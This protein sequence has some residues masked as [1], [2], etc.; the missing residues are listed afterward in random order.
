MDAK[1]EGPLE[2]AL[3]EAQCGVRHHGREWPL[4]FQSDERQEKTNINKKYPHLEP[5]Q[6]LIPQ[7][8]GSRQEAFLLKNILCQVVLY[9]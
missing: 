5:F 6:F 7:I 4:Y 9:M 2:L 8:Q 3:Q 1:W